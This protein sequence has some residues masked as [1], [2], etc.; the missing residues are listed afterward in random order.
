MLRESSTTTAMMF[1]CGLS[2]AIMSAGC[3]SKRSTMAATA[4]CSSQMRP[5]RQ[6]LTLTAAFGRR[7]RISRAK[8]TA[9]AI[10]SRPRTHFGQAPSNTR[11]PLENTA[12]GYLKSNSN[13]IR[14]SV[15]PERDQKPDVK[16]ALILTARP[17]YTLWLPISTGIDA[18][19]GA[20]VAAVRFTIYIIYPGPMRAIECPGGDPR[21][22][23]VIHIESQV[24]MDEQAFREAHSRERHLALRLR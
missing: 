24:P 12:V 13:M 7:E 8:L 19:L 1:C 4:N 21:T 14:L 5:T 22:E 23:R 20:R 16:P 3:H 9:V 6:F 17:P 11:F 18:R 2:S 15:V 10:S